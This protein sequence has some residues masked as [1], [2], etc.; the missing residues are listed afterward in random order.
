MP[1]DMPFVM[2]RPRTCRDRTAGRACFKVGVCKLRRAF[3]W[4]KDN[5]PYY[6][7]VEWRDDAASAW[8]AEDVQVGVVREAQDDFGQA[9]PVSGVCFR[10]WMQLARTEAA[11]A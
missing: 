1:S 3:D 9:P 11:G 4:L 5:D 8:Q 7:G 6:F 10:R 2:V